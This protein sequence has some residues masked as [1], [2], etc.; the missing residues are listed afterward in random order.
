MGTERRRMD[1]RLAHRKHLAEG[2][3]PT[4]V[5]CPACNGQGLVHRVSEA[6]RYRFPRCRWCNSAGLVDRV[7]VD[8]FVR[9]V[10]IRVH[11]EARCNSRTRA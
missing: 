4:L 5:R 3:Q 1:R 6:T 9:W 8:I 7:M 11:N 2:S 10:T